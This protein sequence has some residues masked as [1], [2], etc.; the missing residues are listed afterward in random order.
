VWTSA[1]RKN[2]EPVV[3][4]IFNDA[5]LLFRWYRDRCTIPSEIRWRECYKDLNALWRERPEW[6]PK[7]TILV[8]D[9]PR[10][11]AYQP[12]NCLV[13]PTFEISHHSGQDT[14]LLS[15]QKYL[16]A[17]AHSHM[18][19]R[20]WME[21]HPFLDRSGQIVSKFRCEIIDPLPLHQNE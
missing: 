20:R 4:H 19:V 18:D 10:K 5:P 17:M 7:N 1:K 14:V 21:L 13:V 15:L 16:A 6:S 2:V 12:R 8:D 11:A 9:S 3:N